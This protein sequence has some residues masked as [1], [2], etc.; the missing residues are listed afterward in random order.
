MKTAP[1]MCAVAVEPSMRPRTAREIHAG[2]RVV[3]RMAQSHSQHTLGKAAEMSNNVVPNECS[4]KINGF[5]W[6]RAS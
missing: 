4:P 2:R 5:P 1:L 6:S 3:S